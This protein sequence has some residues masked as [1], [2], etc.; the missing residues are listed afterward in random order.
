MRYW[1]LMNNSWQHQ[2]G[3]RNPHRDDPTKRPP[4]GWKANNMIYRR[5][6]ASAHRLGVASLIEQVKAFESV[7]REDQIIIAMFL[8]QASR[9]AKNA[10]TLNLQ[11]ELEAYRKEHPLEHP[12]T[13]V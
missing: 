4:A 12:A 9:R 7:R 8:E 11:Q 5:I 10:E 3:L 2:H 13:L 1:T 6:V